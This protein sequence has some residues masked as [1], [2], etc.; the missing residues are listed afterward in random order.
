MVNMRKIIN[1]QALK[2]VLVKKLNQGHNMASLNTNVKCMLQE[3]KQERK[4]C[5]VGTSFFEVDELAM[6]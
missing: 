5:S 1:T 2:P 4:Y 6:H 3:A